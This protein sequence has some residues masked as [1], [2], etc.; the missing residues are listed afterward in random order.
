[1]NEQNEAPK[2]QR[3]TKQPDQKLFILDEADDEHGKVKWGDF[4]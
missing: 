1:M 3:G 4:D 2:R